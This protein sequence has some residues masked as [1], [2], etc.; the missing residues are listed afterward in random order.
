M[1]EAGKPQFKENIEFFKL[2][3]YINRL[4]YE[5]WRNTRK[6]FEDDIQLIWLFK[7][8]VIIERETQWLGGSVAGAIWVYKM[9]QEANLD[10]D[11]LI[12]DYGLRNCDNP[13][14]PF[15]SAYYG[16]R[17]IQDY[18]EHNQKIKNS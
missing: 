9:I 5:A 12:A 14:I 2:H 3:D 18:F 13:Y 10:K 15:G 4:P 16:K 11:Y 8:L 6:E 1:D 17:T 7:G